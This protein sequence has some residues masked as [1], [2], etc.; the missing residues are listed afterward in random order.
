[1]EAVKKLIL[2]IGTEINSSKQL[3]KTYFLMCL[4]C[5][6]IQI[7]NIRHNICGEINVCDN[8]IFGLCNII[9]IF[10]LFTKETDSN[11]L[12]SYFNDFSYFKLFV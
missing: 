4:F 9:P 3:I 10:E 7:G 2:F 5:I 11:Q 12:L 8:L 1:M 6:T